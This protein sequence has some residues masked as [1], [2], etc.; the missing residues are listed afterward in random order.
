MITHAAPHGNL[1][2]VCGWCDGTITFG[3]GTTCGADGKGCCCGASGFSQCNV[4]Y[5]K[6]VRGA[7]IAPRP[8]APNPNPNPN[9][10]PNPD[11]NPDPNP[12]LISFRVSQAGRLLTLP[13]EELLLPQ[14][15]DGRREFCIRSQARSSAVRDPKVD[16]PSREVPILLGSQA[17][18]GFVTVFEM[19]PRKACV[20]LL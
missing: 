1:L 12:H 18:H 17:L 8:S 6:E 10:N 9:S 11:P 3:D 14:Q 5:R 20:G 15:A 19:A 13:L 4:A 2:Q 16:Q 7:A